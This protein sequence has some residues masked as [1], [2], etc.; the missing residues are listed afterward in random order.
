MMRSIRGGRGPAPSVEF[1]SCEI[2]I[3]MSA[4][5]T[6]PTVGETAPT[7]HHGRMFQSLEHLIRKTAS[8]QPVSVPPAAK[9]AHE[10]PAMTL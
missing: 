2:G 8:A 10:A 3:R 7:G 4:P 9:I 1:M 6:G 5:S